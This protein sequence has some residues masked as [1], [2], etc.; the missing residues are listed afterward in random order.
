MDSRGINK[1]K[2]LIFK[3]KYVLDFSQIPGMLYE[4]IES[5]GSSIVIWSWTDKCIKN[6]KKFCNKF[7][8]LNLILGVKKK[9]TPKNLRRDKVKINKENTSI[10]P[11]FKIE[12]P[13]NKMVF[14]LTRRN[15]IWN[16]VVFHTFSPF[17]HSLKP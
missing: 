6:W 17:T 16:E 7:W 12:W 5:V 13:L 1:N 11:P 14:F 4:S 9:I 2:L 10:S 3:K 8:A 15:Y